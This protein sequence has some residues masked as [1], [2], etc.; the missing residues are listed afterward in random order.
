MASLHVVPVP[1]QMADPW[2]D[3]AIHRIWDMPVARDFALNH[4]YAGVIQTQSNIDIRTRGAKA[5][6][7]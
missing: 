3:A 5:P 4:N 1:V 2:V 6:P 7:S